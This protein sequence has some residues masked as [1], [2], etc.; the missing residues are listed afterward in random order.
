MVGAGRWCLPGGSRVSCTHLEADINHP[1]TD[2]PQQLRRP[3]GNIDDPTADERT[4]I[5]DAQADRH[6]VGQVG[7]TNFRAERESPVRGRERLAVIGFAVGR[8]VA[9]QTIVIVRCLPFLDRR[10]RTPASKHRSPATP[11]QKS[12]Q[13]HHA[14]VSVPHLRR[15]SGWSYGI[16]GKL[17]LTLSVLG[18]RF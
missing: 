7:Y 10:S 5:V 13:D 15:P 3:T 8:Q 1:L 11:G 16:V 4:A 9:V 17:T 12:D 6:S 2:E 18:V 14:Q